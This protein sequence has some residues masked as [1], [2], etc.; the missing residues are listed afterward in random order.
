MIY[1]NLVN[2]FGGILSQALELWSILLRTLSILD[3]LALWGSGPVRQ[4]G[5]IREFRIHHKALSVRE[6]QIFW[7]RGW[8]R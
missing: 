6:T 4:S 2:R 3:V 1:L 7:S 5:D 8:E